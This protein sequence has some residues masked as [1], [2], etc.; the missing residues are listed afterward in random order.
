MSEPGECARC[1][2]RPIS[3]KVYIGDLFPEDMYQPLRTAAT[4]EVHWMLSDCGVDQ[5]H[6]GSGSL[7]ESEQRTG[8]TSVLSV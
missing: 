2:S 5:Q 1:A 7:D 3:C 4:L 6:N 8:Y